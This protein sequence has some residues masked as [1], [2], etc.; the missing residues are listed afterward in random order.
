MNEWGYGLCLGRLL[1]DLFPHPQHCPPQVFGLQTTSITREISVGLSG[2]M[3]RSLAPLV[4]ANFDS[5]YVSI[6]T[7]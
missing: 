3:I 2:V 5:W 1:V 7:M 6:E 4:K